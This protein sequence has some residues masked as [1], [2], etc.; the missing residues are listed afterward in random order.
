MNGLCFAFLCKFI[1]YFAFNQTV[2]LIACMNP[3]SPSYYFFSRR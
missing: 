2:E 3:Q 1:P